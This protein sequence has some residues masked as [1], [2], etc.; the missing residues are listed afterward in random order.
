MFRTLLTRTPILLALALGALPSIAWAQS[1]CRVMDPELQGSYVG[2]C[3]AGMAEG[4]GTAQGMATY[5]GEFHEGKKHGRGVKTW[6]WGDR[7]EGEFVDDYKD[8]WGV[9]S[10]GANTLFAGDRYEGEFAK[11]R[12]N[13]Y[14]VYVWASGDSYAGPW[15]DDAIAG[16][17]TPLMIARFRATS[18]SLETMA[19]P[20]VRLCHESAIGSAA[21]GRTEGETQAVNAGARQVSVRITRLGPVPAVVAGT[22]VA[23]GD[24]VW[25]GPLHWTPCE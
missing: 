6:S 4:Q 2:G 3:V 19:K 15:K 21:A 12:R 18:A 5:S 16:R 10:W 1:A 22:P 20:G 24:V 11:D 13:G 25:D 8:R 7:Y 23:V 17:A 14:G 9:Y